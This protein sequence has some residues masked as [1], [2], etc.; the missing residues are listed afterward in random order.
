M[1]ET[2]QMGEQ[3]EVVSNNNI[4]DIKSHNKRKKRM[5]VECREL[6]VCIIAG[7]EANPVIKQ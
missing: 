6:T 1:L 7:E 2:E 3:N 5:R 4:F